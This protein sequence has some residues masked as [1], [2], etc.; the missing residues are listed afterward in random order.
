MRYTL[1]TLYGYLTRYRFSFIAYFVVF[2]I[3]ITAAN[4]SPWFYKQLVDNINAGTYQALFSIF[5]FFVFVKL[6][7][8]ITDQISTT[9]KDAFEFRAGRDARVEIMQKIHDLDF[10]FH[11]SKSTGSLISTMK[12]GDGSFYDMSEILNNSLIR[13][14]G[15]LF[16]G[17]FL[18]STIT[19]LLSAIVLGTFLLNLIIAIF[20]VRYNMRARSAWNEEEDRISGIITDN[21]INFD[22]VK[23]FAKEKWETQRLQEAFRIWLRK[24]WKFALTFRAIEITSALFGTFTICAIIYLSITEVLNGTASPGDIVLGLAVVSSFYPTYLQVIYRMRGIAKNYTDLEKYFAL[25]TQEVSVKD[26]KR[27][28]KLA[29]VKGGIEFR[30]VTFL[31]P[32]TQTPVL[33]NFSLDLK[34]GQS[35][36]LVGR[37]GQGKSTIVKL[38]MRF[39]DLSEGQI[40]LDGVDII[41]FRKSDLRSRIGVVPQEPILFNNT[42]EYNIGYG[43]AKPTFQEIEAATKMA[44]LDEFIESLPEKY[45]TNVGERGIKLSGGQKQRLAIARMIL[46]NPDIVIFDEATSHLDSE[47]EKAIQEAFWK[48]V[49]G[50]TAIIVAH[51]LSTIV[52]ADK[53]C[54]LQ[55]GQVVES[56]SHRALLQNKSGIYTHFWNLQTDID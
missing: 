52:R 32:E 41:K 47:S 44:Y 6:L 18:L 15:S 17:A 55:E 46:A 29:Q 26:P 39:Y 45:Q 49:K 51:R 16:M 7:E 8:I 19:P 43:A 42:I 3:S 13:I 36:A 14:L 30:N 48:A 28:Q 53:I 25:L 1:A 24:L 50:K 35:V 10:A 54:V 21:L 33:H 40:L 38:L 5:G 2:L 12:R 22:T 27:P 37:S 23:L 56:G 34:P 20:L 31:Y 11:L 9:L 4:L